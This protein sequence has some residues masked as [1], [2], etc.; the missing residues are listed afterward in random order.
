MCFKRYC[1]IMVFKE[2]VE[3]ERLSM[4]QK[5]AKKDIAFEKERG[6]FRSEIRKLNGII[7][8]MNGII[9][10]KDL[11]I[12]ELEQQIYKLADWNERLLEYMDLSED[13]FK[14]LLESSRVR[15]KIS[16]S[17]KSVMTL[18]ERAGLYRLGDNMFT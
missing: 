12:D 2:N 13:E 4:K 1:D 18:M 14:A 6:K 15:A 8:D 9:S 16:E 5:L 11:K 3:R 10:D 17:C 7:S